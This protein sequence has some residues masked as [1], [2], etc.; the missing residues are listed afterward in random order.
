MQPLLYLK[1]GLQK[2]EAETFS[3]DEGS[4]REPEPEQRLHL[5]RLGRRRGRGSKH[6]LNLDRLLDLAGMRFIVL[7]HDYLMSTTP[8]II[9]LKVEVSCDLFLAQSACLVP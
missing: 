5:R 6:S 7:C 8:F 3:G 1:F 9:R 2:I 4:D